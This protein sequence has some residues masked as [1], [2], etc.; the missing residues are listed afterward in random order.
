MDA[1]IAKIL[2]WVFSLLGLLIVF[3]VDKTKLE[4]Q[5]VRLY[6][7]EM[8]ILCIAS[9]VLCWTVIVPI[10]ICVFWV[11]GLIN[12]IQDKDQPLPLIGNW[13]WFFK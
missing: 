12:I 4:D 5:G 7:N 10:A 9:I 2:I 1:K 3:L 8:I 6:A 11:I 13:N